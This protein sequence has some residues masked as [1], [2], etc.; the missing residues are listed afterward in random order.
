MIYHKNIDPIIQGEVQNFAT[1]LGSYGSWW[2]KLKAG[3]W[4]I[5]SAKRLS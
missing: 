5:T 2:D 4:M 3:D 1:G